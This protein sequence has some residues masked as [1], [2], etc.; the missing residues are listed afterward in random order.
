MFTLIVD[1]CER[2]FFVQQQDAGEQTTGGGGENIFDEKIYLL[3]S[4]IESLACVC[5]QMEENLPEGSIV[6][7]EKL[8]TLAIDSYPR[9]VKRYDY[10]ISLAIARLLMSFQCGK[11]NGYYEFVARIIY[12]SMIRIF[13]YKS[14]YYLQDTAAN[15]LPRLELSP[16]ETISENGG[17]G[18]ENGSANH[19]SLMNVTSSH[20]VQIWS[21]LFGLNE[22]K[23]LNTV[24]VVHGDE[25]K[26][27]IRLIYDE[28]MESIIK[29]MKKLD[30]NAVRVET[31]EDKLHADAVSSNPIVG[32]RPSRP[33]DFEIFINLVDFTK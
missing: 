10:Q 4:F 15:N 12:Q 29:I 30:L 13:S 24:G 26:K 11:F 21:N 31:D 7:L 6:T 22:F 3:P 8:V 5:N 20:Y 16:N 9:L 2:T 25:K 33:K 32:L 28:Y 27:L 23:D 14:N 1:I 17:S 19:K 18:G